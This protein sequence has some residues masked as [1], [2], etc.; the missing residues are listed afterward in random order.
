[1]VKIQLEFSRKSFNSLLN[2]FFYF[3][4]IFYLFIFE[5]FTEHVI[6]RT[7]DSSALPLS[8][9]ENSALQALKQQNQ[10]RK[11][12]TDKASKQ[13]GSMVL[14]L[15][16]M[17][18]ADA[19]DRV[20]TLSSQATATSTRISVLWNAREQYRLSSIQIAQNYK[21]LLEKQSA[22]LLSL[23]TNDQTQIQDPKKGQKQSK[24]VPS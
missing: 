5:Q 12:S 6:E 14:Q 10:Q 16:E 15:N 9:I 22:K 24:K 2:L 3:Y 18:R 8:R 13:I 4:T 11:E 20:L 7:D 19:A 21:L 1:M 23:V 17:L